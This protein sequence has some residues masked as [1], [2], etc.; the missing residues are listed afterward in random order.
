MFTFKAKE[1]FEIIVLDLSKMFKWL[2][3]SLASFYALKIRTLDISNHMSMA[4]MA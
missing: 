4:N 1:N 3:T 2:I